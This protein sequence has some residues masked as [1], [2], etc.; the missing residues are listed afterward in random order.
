MKAA[1]KYIEEHTHDIIDLWEEK[2]NKEIS[3]SETT[4]SMVLRN[5]LPNLLED[6]STVL[7][8][9]EGKKNFLKEENCSE[10]VKKSIDHGRH[11]AT[12]SHYTVKQ[13]IREYI[14]LN[15]ALTEL[16]ISKDL[17]SEDISVLLTY[18]LETSMSHSASSF[19]DSIQEMREKLVGTLAHDIR[20]PISA[21]YFAIDIMNYADGEEKFNKL[22]KT[23]R[24][25]LKRS[26]DLMEGLLDAISVK[27]GEGVTLNFQKGNIV[28]ELKS[29]YGEAA[30]IYANEIVLECD[31]D[32]ITGVYDGTAVRRILENLI[33][34][35]IKYGA[36]DKPIRIILKKHE[37]KLKLSVHNFGDPI[38]SG[39]KKIIFDFLSRT[40]K[41]ASGQLQS[42]GMGLTFVKM[43]AEAHGGHVELISNE[44]EGTIFS[45]IL[46]I[47]SNEP[48]KKRARLN[49]SD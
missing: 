35:A 16:L 6:I 9:N 19:T 28:E 39:N 38:A 31:E 5:L 48:G 14:V 17:H 15:Q 21:A 1:A 8:R 3:A 33:T 29:V 32:E 47:K 25:S 11:R 36:Q 30:R 10:I 34:N 4:N 46:D 40:D 2:V 18:I 45:V 22:K 24:E 41:E 42:W 44:E 49:L 7:K 13:I 26:I 23:T 20:N 27:A 37:G 12:S 43:G